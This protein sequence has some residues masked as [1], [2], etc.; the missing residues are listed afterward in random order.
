MRGPYLIGFTSSFRMGQVL[1]Y[2][3]D[4]AE[5]WDWEHDVDA[6][7]ATRF[8]D[9]VRGAFKDAGIGKK[10]H[11]IEEGGTFLVGFGGVLYK[12]EA[13]YQVARS[14][15]PFDACGSGEACALAALYATQG[16][17]LTAEQRITTA[18]SAAARYNAAVRPPFVVVRV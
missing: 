13:D 3:A 15:D 6:F 8:I 12:I 4:L 7:M 2:R 11:D 16:S 9:S 10:E 18:L 17:G 1:R 14:A 5:P